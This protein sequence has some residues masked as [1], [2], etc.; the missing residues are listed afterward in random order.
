MHA[1]T[2]PHARMWLA[3]ERDVVMEPSDDIVIESLVR[4]H[5]M[6]EATA[7]A[8]PQRAQALLSIIGGALMVMSYFLP[9]F[10]DSRGQGPNGAPE[11]E[12]LWDTLLQVANLAHGQ[13]SSSGQPHIFVGVL[14]GLPIIMGA[15][16][17]VLGVLSLLRDSG[18][19]GRGFGVAAVLFAFVASIFPVIYGA[20]GYGAS[21]GQALP[22]E[23]LIGLGSVALVLGLFLATAAAFAQPRRA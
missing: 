1:A 17:A 22:E 9:T 7:P 13:S 8:R 14:F 4:S 12:S 23:S 21:H 3:P 6:A 16:I 20:V 11:I 2:S 10:L 19:L 18:D 5:H 15:V